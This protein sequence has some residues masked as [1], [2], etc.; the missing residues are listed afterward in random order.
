MCKL[1]QNGRCPVKN[2]NQWNPLQVV[3]WKDNFSCELGEWLATCTFN[4]YIAGDIQL[5]ST[6]KYCP[7]RDTEKNVTSNQERLRN[8]S[9]LSLRDV[10]SQEHLQLQGLMRIHVSCRK[11]TQKRVQIGNSCAWKCV[12]KGIWNHAT[13]MSIR[14]TTK[15][16]NRRIQ[17]ELM[18]DLE[19][20]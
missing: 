6:Y 5:H 20:D 15:C 8:G 1:A 2:K 11:K 4:P 17:D 18:T 12:G 14:G 16:V 19:V 3:T 7:T 10:D 9:L 13:C